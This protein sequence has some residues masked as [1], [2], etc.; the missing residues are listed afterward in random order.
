MIFTTAHVLTAPAAIPANLQTYPMESN[1]G[2]SKTI[3]II[4]ER[5][6]TAIESSTTPT[7]GVDRDSFD[8]IP[9]FSGEYGADH[10]ARMSCKITRP[11]PARPNAIIQSANAP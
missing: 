4:D 6:T 11:I 3:E 2:A 5:T 8:E 9:N 10:H 1:V 7:I